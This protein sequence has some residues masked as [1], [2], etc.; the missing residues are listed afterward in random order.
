MPSIFPQWTRLYAPPAQFLGVITQP[1]LAKQKQAATISTSLHQVFPQHIFKA[2]MSQIPITTTCHP[3][4]TKYNTTLFPSPSRL[5]PKPRANNLTTTQSQTPLLISNTPVY[6][7]VRKKHGLQ[8]TR[9]GYKY[10]CK[11]QNWLGNNIS[12]IDELHISHFVEISNQPFHRQ[13]TQ[14]IQINQ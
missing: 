3:P 2:I 14:T 11:S 10:H 9:K 7:T 12:Q 13:S 5:T 4:I 1:G 6:V 8:K